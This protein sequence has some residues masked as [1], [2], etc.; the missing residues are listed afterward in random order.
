MDV[1]IIYFMLLSSFILSLHC[2]RKYFMETLGHSSRTGNF[3]EKFSLHV[4]VAPKSLLIFKQW[5]YPYEK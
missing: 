1:Y 5:K 4:I 2:V 3:L